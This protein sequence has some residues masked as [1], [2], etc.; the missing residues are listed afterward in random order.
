[1]RKYFSRT[2][3]SFPVQ[4]FWCIFSTAI[5]LLIV[6]LLILSNYSAKTALKM[7]DD[8]MEENLRITAN[9]IA[10]TFNEVDNLAYTLFAQE[11]VL[12]LTKQHYSY[13]SE[14]YNTI[15]T[16]V[17]RTQTSSPLV[18]DVVFCDNRGNLFTSNPSPYHSSN[19]YVDLDT[20]RAYL[21]SLSDYTSDNNETWYFLHPNFYGTSQY[22][23]VN[24]RSV[25]LFSTEENPLLLIYYT[26]NKLTELYSF[27]GE[28][29]FIMTP[30]GKIVS[31]VDKTLLGETVEESLCKRIAAEKN[32]ISFELNGKRYHSSFCQVLN[33]YLV[34]PSDSAVLAQVNR[35]TTVVTAFIL[36]AGILLSIV[37]SRLISNSMSRPL[38]RLKRKMEQVQSGDLTVR[39]ESNRQDEIGYLCHSFN[40]MMDMVNQYLQQHE[41]QHMLAQKAELQL[42]Q[43][44][45]NPHLLYNSLDSAL[46]LLTSNHSEQSCKVLEELSHF[47]RLSLQKGSRIVKVGE[48]IELVKTYLRLQNLC[49]MKDY[50]LEVRGDLTVL[51][52]SIL[53]MCMQPIVENSV[54]HGLAGSYTDGMIEIIL[55]REE[56]DILIRIQD[57]G[58]GMDDLQLEQLQKRLNSDSAV[59]GGYGLWNVAQRIKIHYGKNYGL[60]IDSELGE[61]TAVTL[62]LPT[63]DSQITE[64]NK[65]V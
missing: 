40:Y 20:C 23:F 39:C 59:D 28:N 58:V 50:K 8:R 47:F 44:Q 51:D 35:S 42:M 17:I 36:L 65:H 2:F 18:S 38:V 33:C 34:V 30:S 49:R 45:I 12:A 6:G 5:I 22:T 55:S 46:Y 15:R 24:V 43:A 11:N 29:S 21:N 31:A 61:Y 63:D 4:L 27:L 25:N 56:N 7:N 14:T 13:P 16:A 53:H 54:L 1:M 41:Q 60:S 9:N 3:S 10:T 48:S 52:S 37:W 19:T 57:D 64:E 32:A 62:R 26:E